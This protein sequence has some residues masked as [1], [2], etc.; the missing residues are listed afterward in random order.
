MESKLDLLIQLLASYGI[1]ATSAEDDPV[2]EV[3]VREDD[4]YFV[5]FDAD[6]RL[7]VSHAIYD[8]EVGL[9]AYDDVR[10]AADALRHDIVETLRAY[11]AALGTPKPAVYPHSFV[12]S[13][14][15]ATQDPPLVVPY[16]FELLHK[17]ET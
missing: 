4:S 2:I 5:S 9:G 7:A 3:C 16:G 13:V 10:A 8:V 17:D 14:L 15:R 6:S 12:A 1:T 11:S